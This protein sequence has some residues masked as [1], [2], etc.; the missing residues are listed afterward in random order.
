ML[1]IFPKRTILD[2][3]QVSEYAFIL[4]YNHQ[5]HFFA[6]LLLWVLLNHIFKTFFD[7]FKRR[8]CF[9]YTNFHT[10][11]NPYLN[12]CNVLNLPK[13]FC[14]KGV[15]KNFKKFTGKHLRQN[16]SFNKVAGTYDNGL[17]IDRVAHSSSIF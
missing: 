16:L 11:Y 13:V 4:V 7:I 5:L 14:K 12:K 8:I 10:N 2:V 17:R 3:W 15:L 9:K 1:T 6:S